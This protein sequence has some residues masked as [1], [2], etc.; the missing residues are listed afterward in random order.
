MSLLDKLKFWKK[1]PVLDLGPEPELGL[2]FGRGYENKDAFEQGFPQDNQPSWQN[3]MQHP[4]GFQQQFSQPQQTYT[5]S[6][7]LS[8]NIEVLSSKLDAL[9]AT[10]D[11][12][13]QRLE[14][15]EQIARYEQNKRKGW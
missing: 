14:N 11:A 5:Q 9:K 3:P 13:S 12:I 8:K 6:D 15:L 1:E 2:E 7:I 4:Q 10:L